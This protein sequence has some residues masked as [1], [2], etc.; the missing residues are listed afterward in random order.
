MK[1]A[2]NNNK[3]CIIGNAIKFTEAGKVT[4]SLIATDRQITISVSDTGIGIEKDKF[5]TIWTEL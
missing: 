4:A 3:C 5:A 2:Y 1:S